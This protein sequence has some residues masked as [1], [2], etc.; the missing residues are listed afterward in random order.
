[1]LW[2]SPNRFRLKSAFLNK[3]RVVNFRPKKFS[4]QNVK[5]YALSVS[6]SVNTK[7]RSRRNE[8]RFEWFYWLRVPYWPQKASLE[9]SP[10]LM[11]S[12][13]GDI[14]SESWM[15]PFD[16]RALLE[17]NFF[18]IFFC[19]PGNN[20]WTLKNKFTNDDNWRSKPFN[21]E[22]CSTVSYLLRFGLLE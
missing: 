4:L 3:N 13:N 16:P 9:P 8:G 12:S 7:R 6:I 19:K 20:P 18:L 21:I 11:P 14:L 22:K 5:S 2:K 10:D 15:I 1:M 17:T